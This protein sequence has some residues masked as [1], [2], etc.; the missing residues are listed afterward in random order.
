MIL[1]TKKKKKLSIDLIFEE[2]TQIVQ[3]VKLFV[4]II[5]YKVICFCL[6]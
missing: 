4:I 6:L 3:V 5:N 1:L 2:L